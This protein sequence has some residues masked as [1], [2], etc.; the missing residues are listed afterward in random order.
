AEQSL[1][2]ALMLSEHAW[3]KVADRLTEGDFY[4]ETHRLIFRAIGELQQNHQPSDAVTLADW[5]GRNDLLDRVVAQITGAGPIT[6]ETGVDVGA[7]VSMDELLSRHAAVFLGMGLMKSRGLGID[8]EETPG[9]EPGLSFLRRV[10]AGETVDAGK[11]AVVIGGGNTAMDVAR[12]ALRAGADVT[13][14]YRRTRNEM[15]AIAEEI[16]EAEREGVAFRFL[17]APAEIVGSKKGL[18]KIVCQEM[19]LGEPDE[20]GRRRPVPIEGKTF[21]LAADRLFTAIGEQGDLSGIE[22]AVETERHL[23]TTTG[24]GV[25]TSDERIF[26]GGDVTTGAASVVEAVAAGRRAAG[27]IA[28]RIAGEPDYEPADERTVGIE[29]M[30]LAYF[31]HEKR[32]PLPRITADQARGGFD[33]IFTGFDADALAREAD[34][35]FSCG[36]C[37]FCDNCWMY[38]PDVAIV[39]NEAEEKYEIDLDFCKG[40][41]VCVTECPRNALSIE[42]EGK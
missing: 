23:V 9:V 32:V 37:N 4:R 13:V 34:R 42:E 29:D 18:E 6:V 28:A 33:E 25:E 36:V 15:P 12:C 35:C 19:E 1:L 22:G 27:R 30:N 3:D 31:S 8:G 2:G 11:K 38:C 5:F 17:A 21:E 16:E 10:N 39:R 20:S 26:A 24:D 14:V 7:D 40:C 41:L